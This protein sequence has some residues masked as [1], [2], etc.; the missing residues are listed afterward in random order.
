[1]GEYKA[2]GHG[3]KIKPSSSSNS[4]SGSGFSKDQ[5]ADKIKKEGG[6]AA[7]QALGV[8]KP[9]AD[10][11]GKQLA[12]NNGQLPGMR[13]SPILPNNQ[14]KKPKESGKEKESDKKNDSKSESAKKEK[15][16][17]KNT[18]LGQAKQGIDQLKN[19]DN[20]EDTAKF[21]FDLIKALVVAVPA[22]ISVLP[23]LLVIV[24]IGALLA[25]LSNYGIIDNLSK[26]KPLNTVASNQ[27]EASSDSANNLVLIGDSRTVGMYNS[28]NNKSE[29]LKVNTTDSNKVSWSAYGGMGYYWMEK[30][31]VPQ[32]ESKIVQDTA[33]VI[34][35]GVN[36]LGNV[37]K[38]IKYIN[39]K[40]TEWK[41]K[42][43]KTYFVSVNPINE[44]KARRNGYTPTN[45]MI[46]NFNTKLKS[47]ISGVSYIDTYNYIKGDMASGTQDGVHYTK[48]VYKKIYNKIV[49]ATGVGTSGQMGPTNGI[50]GKFYAPVQRKLTMYGADS[51]NGGFNHD[52][53][54]SK[55]EKVYS[56]ADGTAT[57]ETKLRG[58]RVAS[59][60]NVI[61]ITTSDGYKFKLAHL[62][63]FVG[64]K[65]KYGASSTGIS[66]YYNSNCSTYTYGSRKVKK[67]ELV[68]TVG[69]SGNTTG[70]PPDHLHFEVHYNGVRKAP[71]KYVG[72]K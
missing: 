65:L 68:G 31:G 66:C 42:G 10:L 41:S 59:Y 13:K 70:N 26:L 17:L 16:L 32:I 40:A 28:V 46:N 19:L 64:Y 52:I 5:L 1:M 29:T 30:T 60:G 56:P 57:F 22:F 43:A 4:S 27:T 54:A 15:D 9:I 49:S 45:A 24:F 23:V 21:T 55:G 8:P 33:V 67:G 11:G 72:Y 3:D 50:Q 2:K 36:D 47:G 53:S 71:E 18:K 6:S 58:G 35:M 34:L 69:A 20:E 37:D 51:K 48:T 12:K 61:T 14:S 39:N 44:T 63:S 62:N 7:L 38:Y 25:V